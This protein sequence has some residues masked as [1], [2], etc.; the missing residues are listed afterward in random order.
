MWA[1]AGR[2][3][4]ARI[5]PQDGFGV[6]GAAGSDARL[7][8]PFLWKPT[9]HTREGGHNGLAHNA[10]G[11]TPLRGHTLT[12]GAWERV[13]RGAARPATGSAAR[14]RAL[15]GG[16][17]DRSERKRDRTTHREGWTV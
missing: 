2:W 11:K 7:P 5:A 10:S 3:H 13:R 17:D 9:V 16:G 8:S 15:D 12:E 6:W 1:E 14:E 4:V